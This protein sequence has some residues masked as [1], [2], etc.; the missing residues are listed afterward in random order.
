[1]GNCHNNRYQPTREEIE[2]GL[3]EKYIKRRI[4]SIPIY[5]FWG[6][7]QITDYLWVPKTS[8]TDQT[9]VLRKVVLKYNKISELLAFIDSIHK[10]YVIDDDLKAYIYIRFINHTPHCKSYATLQNKKT[11]HP[12]L[13]E[14]T[15]GKDECEEL[16]KEET[17][18]KDELP[19]KLAKKKQCK[20][21]KKKQKL[22]QEKAMY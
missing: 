3:R 5:V 12:L 13:K 20:K 21:G 1:M 18:G 14:E 9:L 17:I 19:E 10:P 11:A 4:L 7:Y 22:R 15:I 2:D 16:L 8:N 6:N